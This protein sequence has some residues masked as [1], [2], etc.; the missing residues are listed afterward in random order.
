MINNIYILLNTNVCQI[1]LLIINVYTFILTSFYSLLLS[2]QIVI[3]DHRFLELIPS[4]ACLWPSD[5][6]QYINLLYSITKYLVI[7]KIYYI[8]SR[9]SHIT[10]A[11]NMKQLTTIYQFQLL[12]SQYSSSNSRYI[13]VVRSQVVL[14]AISLKF[15]TFHFFTSSTLVP[16][17]MSC[18]TVAFYNEGQCVC[19]AQN[20]MRK[21]TQRARSERPR[22]ALS[23]NLFKVNGVF[24]LCV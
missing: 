14:N 3:K 13:L 12:Y 10:S 9:R 11:S 2:F 8:Y 17:Y 1:Q 5:T 6:S 20:R 24:Y 15:A 18:K 23:F 16:T 4:G 21:H 7:I 22:T 19:I